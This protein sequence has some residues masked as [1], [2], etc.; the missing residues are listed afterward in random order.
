MKGNQRK[1]K[2]GV[3]IGIALT[4]GMF[5]VIPAGYGAP[6]HD[7]AS[8]YN[9]G[10]AVN[11]AGKVTTVAG[12][13][14]NNVV[15]W[16][17]FSVGRDESVNFEGNKNYL[18]I[19]T[20]QNTSRIDGKISGGNEVYLVNP[21]G[22]IMGKD[23]SVKTGSFY[24]STRYVDPNTAKNAV[25]AGNMSAVLDGSRLLAADIVNL[26]TIEADK[27]V[28]EGQNIRFLD[29]ERV[30]VNSVTF[31]ANETDG[32][33]HVGNSAG[34]TAAGYTGNKNI[35]YYQT[36]NSMAEVT[37][38]SQ[39]YMLS[40]DIKDDN[41]SVTG[42]YKGKFDGMGFTV[43]GMTTDKG[44]LFQATDGA[45]IENVGVVRSTITGNEGTGAIVGKAK[46]TI[47]SNVFNKDTKIK[48]NDELFAGGL[49]GTAAG[50]VSIKNSYNTGS[51][52]EGKGSGIIGVVTGGHTKIDSCYST[53]NVLYG[54]TSV[55]NKATAEVNNSYAVASESGFSDI[56]RKSSALFTTKDNGETYE[57]KSVYDSEGSLVGNIGGLDFKTASTYGTI[58]DSD[59]KVSNTGGVT[60]DASGNVSRP[61][62]R[63]YEG[64]TLPFLT[65]QLKGTTTVDYTYALGGQT[66]KN[67]GAD[68][69]NLTYAA[70]NMTASD[71]SLS[72]N[73]QDS[74]FETAGNIRDAG[75]KAFIYGS[76][77]GWDIVGGTVT[78]NKKKVSFTGGNFAVDR[79]YDGTADATKAFINALKNG[80]LS[81]GG[82]YAE[83]VKDSNSGLD[84]SNVK[85]NY[86]SKNVGNKTVTA[87]GTITLTDALSKNYELDNGGKLDGITGITGRITPRTLYV[88]SNADGSIDKFY[89]GDAA[90]KNLALANGKSD[91]FELDESD[92][93]HTKVGGDDVGLVQ[94]A[95]NNL[96]YVDAD[97]N[98]EKNVVDGMSVK[99]TGLELTGADKDNYVLAYKDSQNHI[100]GV[101]NNTVYLEGK[102][103]RR[104]ISRDDF[105]AWKDG[106]AASISKVYDGNSDFKPDAGLT[107]INDSTAANAGTKNDDGKGILAG[108]K[109]KL[110][111]GLT[112]TGKF[113]AADGT[114]ETADAS[115]N[116]NSL[117]QAKKVGYDV[118]VSADDEALLNNYQI[119]DGTS[120]NALSHYKKGSADSLSVLGDGTITRRT[121]SVGLL[122]NVKD[123]N[124]TYDGT[125]AVT[126][127]AL[128]FGTD[129][130][131]NTGSATL[132][133]S[134]SPNLKFTIK[135]AYDTKDVVRDNDRKVIANGK[136]IDISLGL[137]GD[138]SL[139]GNY[140]VNGTNGEA[141][142]GANA[143]TIALGKGTGAI[144]PRLLNV[145]FKELDKTFD[146]SSSLLQ[147]NSAGAAFTGRGNSGVVNG[148]TLGVSYVKGYYA[149]ADGKE[150]KNATN[151]G[152][153]DA[154]QKIR[155]EGVSLTGK[156]KDNYDLTADAYDG[157]GQILSK[158]LTDRDI[159]VIFADKISKVYDTSNSVSYDH[160]NNPSFF[161]GENGRADSAD[162]I[163]DIT[164][165]GIK[166]AA[167]KDYT[168]A[169]AFY[170][171]PNI[172]ANQATYKFKLTSD[173]LKN[174][175]LS[176]LTNT[177]YD[178]ASGV[179]TKSTSN[180]VSITPKKL[181]ASLKNFGA[182]FEKTY[183][184]SDKLDK[185]QLQNVGAGNIIQLDGV[186]GN[187]A[188][189][190]TDKINGRYTD[191]NVAYDA[192]GNIVNKDILFDVVLTGS[193]S[194]N[195]VLD[196]TELRGDKLGRI[197]PK[198]L[199]ADFDFTERDYKGSSKADA[200]VTG[201]HLTGVANGDTITLK[202][203]DITGVFGSMDA[204][205]SFAA[206][207]D[208]NYDESAANKA[209]Y[210]GVRY[211]GLQQ[212][213]NNAMGTDHGN[214]VIADTKYYSAADKK[215]RINR[216]QLS[217]NDIEAVFNGTAITKEYDG[218]S[219]VLDPE[220]YFTIRTKNK[221]DGEYVDFKVAHGD[222]WAKYYTDDTYSKE[223]INVTNN[224]KVKFEVNGLAADDTLHNFDITG[225]T[226]NDFKG[227]YTAGGT[228]TPRVLKVNLTQADGWKKTYDGTTAIKDAAGNVVN[229]FDYTFADGHDVIAA[230]KG[231]VNVAVTG[232]YD[233]ANAGNGV[234]I[235]Y[236]INLT[237]SAA[238]N[239][240]L[241]H[242]ANAG[243]AA[244]TASGKGDIAKRRLYVDYNN[245]AGASLNKIDKTYD[246]TKNVK[247]LSDYQKN[248]YVEGKTKDSGVVDADAGLDL[249]K[250]G[251]RAEYE[252]PDVRYN[253][254]NLASQDVTF[255]G[256]GLN[257]ADKA[258][259]YEL[260]VR[261]DKGSGII[262]PKDID[263]WVD[264]AQTIRKDYDGTYNLG[265]NQAEIDANLAAI[266]NG[267]R[268][269]DSGRETNVITGKKDV[270]N[271]TVGDASYDRKDAGSS[272]GLD[273]TLGWDNKNY[274][275]NLKA[276][277]SSKDFSA[278]AAGKDSVKVATKQGEITQRELTI[279]PNVLAEISKTYDGTTAWDGD[280]AKN[281]TF[282]NV[283]GSDVL[284]VTAD[285]EFDDANAADSELEN[286]KI[287]KV[288]YKNIS[289]ANKNYKLADPDAEAQGSGVI[290]RAGLTVTADEAS[291][292]SGEPLP[293]YHGTI[294]GW[295]QKDGDAY[296]DSFTFDAPDADSR[297]PGKYGIYGWYVN[298]QGNKVA[299]GNVGKNYVFSQ[300]AS[301]DTAL[302]VEAVDPGR[303]YHDT[304][305]PGSQFR[306][307]HTSYEQ[308]S[309]D[310]ASNF[311]HGTSTALEYRDANGTVLGTLTVSGD[312]DR[313]AAGTE[314]MDQ[315][316][317]EIGIA[318]AEVINMDGAE[319]ASAASIRIAD[320]GDVV[321]LELESI[322]PSASAAVNDK[323]AE[324]ALE[325]G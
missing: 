52:N 42:T 207:G 196:K 119:S 122:K 54:F 46:D 140:I 50:T 31:K 298:A 227:S 108:D 247:N 129:A 270:I 291:I 181:K 253:G 216:L 143:N 164:I 212:A 237:G 91:L 145:T 168:I 26:G 21:N 220:K 27:V 101:T 186:I 209:G 28:V 268:L 240:K 248:F 277:D 226:G 211:S 171:S 320:S 136:T 173:A 179:L 128:I 296:K 290:H 100:T 51:V 158:M 178:S 88:T 217:K 305:N 80:G 71:A 285:A 134:D 74:S 252:S 300:A 262:S 294:A 107:L 130:G 215:G 206:N 6:V 77:D 313:T 180:G 235:T 53:G 69:K 199:T 170:N 190:D 279:D 287:H 125:T 62:W 258:K 246:G 41:T 241:E 193:G 78:I 276:A 82:F 284:D 232:S 303:E 37:N 273:Y 67:N 243:S 146:N 278:S 271:L 36:I 59:H 219:A 15:A 17:D 261:K 138:A 64:Q 324:I 89:D 274:R 132:T 221:I 316:K 104:T 155:Y 137:D 304:V 30:K 182:F 48:D 223:Q 39:N 111:F 135:A 5:S 281:L 228:I 87:T 32:T 105:K 38:M 314:Q 147:D 66:G 126:D 293:G 280:A 56:D 213:L 106:A 113:Y 225:L 197:N 133:D 165:G 102:I 131:Y 159:S 103:N 254:D 45:T 200:K 55:V 198:E 90:V 124:K 1:E 153:K 317:A 120:E 318:G 245:A 299:S 176:Q 163:K 322:E 75:T 98:K 10:A 85:A 60:W 81:S 230:D 302:T 177:L 239:Y 23:A 117:K 222:D 234:G 61:V 73:A 70:A 112:G 83:D 43:T 306:P 210:K 18:N 308:A 260:V 47:L 184:G 238:S 166:L 282:N 311:N 16:K 121:L 49:V 162:Y 236:T 94:A 149:D 24:A 289:I 242:A 321:N 99:Y 127:G 264:N 250:S 161:A 151:S 110:H 144:T 283:I 263:V 310:F 35:D 266:K 319:A 312:V 202:D 93:E 92:K 76:Q 14:Q 292:R 188:A 297:K 265:E 65:S 68:V 231:T 97:K 116:V 152:L 214:Y 301:N 269:D 208:V 7:S 160:T 325:R 139:A 156:D 8:S 13:Q 205:G 167:D 72:A 203:T 4:A 323:E 118:Q 150:T 191:K 275:L 175:D 259:N 224:G 174:F 194:G 286:E 95:A 251:I 172:D 79:E 20:G 229:S 309:Q 272:A 256:F 204:S 201:I 109:D 96:Y 288:T 148:D 11:T 84:V 244:T 25:N 218:T 267:I 114:T 233:D 19:V 123:V 44:G 187:T 29:S 12:N 3:S 22:V 307:D 185:N 295:Y 249:D 57:A 154:A 169:S 58:F 63:I 115:D 141:M 142:L 86:D 192:N 33:I 257:D 9:T 157:K 2:L 183:D 34:R 255:G 40:N 195:Y 189:A 315:K